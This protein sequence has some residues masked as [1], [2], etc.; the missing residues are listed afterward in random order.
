[1]HRVAFVGGRLQRIG[2][3]GLIELV[4]VVIVFVDLV[5]VADFLVVLV[6]TE[7][8][9]APPRAIPLASEGLWLVQVGCG[10]RV[11]RQV[12]GVELEVV[13]SRVER[14]HV[15][16]VGVIGLA[17]RVVQPILEVHIQ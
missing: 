8:P 14:E 5:K 4:K 12:M 9:Q 3:G 6:R 7:E 17:A 11:E 10:V 2:L 15:T 1:M 13:R 16:G